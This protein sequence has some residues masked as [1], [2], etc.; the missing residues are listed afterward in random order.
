VIRPE[1][2]D[3]L[4]LPFRVKYGR[5]ES[6][7]VYVPGGAISW[8]F[9]PQPIRVVVSDVHVLVDKQVSTPDSEET[10]LKQQRIKTD[11][12]ELDSLLYRQHIAD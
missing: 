4:Q 12:L 3:K 11:A 5:V 2:F 7:V 10:N 6:V 9:N 1:I 8:Y